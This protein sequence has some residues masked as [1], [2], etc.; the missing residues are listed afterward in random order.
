VLATADAPKASEKIG[1]KCGGDDMWR[2]EWS[3]DGRY[4]MYTFDMGD[5]GANGVWVWEIATG[6]QRLV[7]VANA[8]RVAAG[9]SG[10]LAVDVGTY[11][12]IGRSEGGFP[13]LLTDGGMPAWRPPLG[14][15]P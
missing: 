9:P 6:Q 7:S 1:G 13:T 14:G 2:T 8:W 12:F 15:T 10:L 4:V 11:M 5:T 3:L